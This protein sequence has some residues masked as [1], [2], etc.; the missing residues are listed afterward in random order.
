MIG[1]NLPLYRLNYPLSQLLIQ[2]AFPQPNNYHLQQGHP[3]QKNITKETTKTKE[4]T[5][6]ALLFEIKPQ[7]LKKNPKKMDYHIKTVT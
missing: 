1:N 4:P 7:I 3:S 6:S 5:K 2:N